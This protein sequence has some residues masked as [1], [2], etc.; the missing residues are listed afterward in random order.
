MWGESEGMQG[1]AV[2]GQQGVCTYHVWNKPQDKVPG[3]NWETDE[4]AINPL[5]YLQ[6]YMLIIYVYKYINI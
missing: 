1:N 4:K 6:I 2:K 5:S 3:R